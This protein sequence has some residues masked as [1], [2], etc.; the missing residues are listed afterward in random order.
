[1]QGLQDRL[2]KARTCGVTTEQVDEISD[3]C[4]AMKRVILCSVC[5]KNPTAV[6]LSKCWHLFCHGCIKSRLGSRSRKCPTCGVA[7]GQADVHEV[8]F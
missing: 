3:E 2:T 6:V 4:A 5:N 7:F 1:M 8:F